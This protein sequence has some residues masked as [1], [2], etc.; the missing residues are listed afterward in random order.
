VSKKSQSSKYLGIQKSKGK[1]LVQKG[2][3]H[4]YL[5]CEKQK[6]KYEYFFLHKALMTKKEKGKKSSGAAL[7]TNR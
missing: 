2:K 7:A 5:I 3:R 6:M 4:F 1:Y